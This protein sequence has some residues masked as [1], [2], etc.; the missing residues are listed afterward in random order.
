MNNS[1]KDLAMEEKSSGLIKTALV[2]DKVMI[3]FSTYAGITAL[4]IMSL[5]ILI[6]VIM[7][8]L[9]KMPNMWGEEISRYL[10]VLGVYLGVACGCRSRSHLA[11]EGLVAVLPKKLNWAIRLF[12]KVVIILA[13]GFFT[14]LIFKLGFTQ[15]KM[16]QTSPAMRLPMWIVY[17]GL[18][19]CFL[20]ACLTE[21]LLFLND[22]VVKK[23]FLME[24]KKK[25]FE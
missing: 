21:I 2:I 13:F 24:D 25:G 7:R 22:F 9:L 20:C 1:S 8:F 17:A 18:V 19:F 6:G 4:S 14:V 15:F 3:S 12:C 16:G 11:V 23:P 10:M 5:A